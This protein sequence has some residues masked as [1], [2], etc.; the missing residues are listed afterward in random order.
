MSGSGAPLPRLSPCT[1]FLF[2]AVDPCASG[3]LERRDMAPTVELRSG[4]SQSLITI[5]CR[6]SYPGGP[7]RTKRKHWCEAVKL[8]VVSEENIQ[9]SF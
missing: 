3:V 8:K 4:Q 2:C 1:V 7:L 6:E 9:G 5:L